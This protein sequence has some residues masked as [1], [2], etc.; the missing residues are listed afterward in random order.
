V[1]CVMRKREED[2]KKEKR[3]GMARAQRAANLVG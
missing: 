3:K 2:G 1:V